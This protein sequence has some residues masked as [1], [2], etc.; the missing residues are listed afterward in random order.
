M[1]AYLEYLNAPSKVII[2]LVAVFLGIQIVGEILEFK[3][4]VV[5]EFV[6][7]RKYF[8]RK[9]TERE[10][11]QDLP[12]TLKKVK[13]SL[14]KVNQHY[15]EDNI[16][17]RDEWIQNVN[18]KLE[19]HDN[20][21]KDFDEKLDANTEITRAIQIDNK[22]TA[23]IDF[24]ARVVD[25]NVPVTHEQFKRAFKLYDEYEAIIKEH[26]MTNGEIDVAHRIIMES[27][28]NH[29]RNHTFIEDVRGY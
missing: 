11:L 13:E 5:P 16:A 21:R 19:E 22:R 12:E 2:I 29:L 3:G 14:D 26:N 28:E 25:E 1:L 15:S 18:S 6:K 24:A 17:M 27:Y 8:A 23:I 20:W 10:T 7:I 4:K 9:K